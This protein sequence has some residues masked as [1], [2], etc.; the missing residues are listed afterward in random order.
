ATS[1]GIASA[2]AVSR[3]KSM[4][5]Q[6]GWSQPTR[7]A[8]VQT[9][10]SNNN[11]VNYSYEAQ[12]VRPTQIASNYRPADQS[13]DESS[14]DRSPGFVQMQEIRSNN[15][16]REATP[17]VSGFNEN[18]TD[19][20]AI[21]AQPRASVT[22][23]HNTIMEPARQLTT[24]S[25]EDKEPTRSRRVSKEW[26]NTLIDREDEGSNDMVDE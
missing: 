11:V 20:D 16:A 17:H 21:Y 5:R 18:S 4:E 3:L 10:G 8:S 25:I 26:G 15:T 2:F 22:A 6:F 19:S 7:L 14:F 9:Y 23:V 13:V 1:T 12:P 24:I